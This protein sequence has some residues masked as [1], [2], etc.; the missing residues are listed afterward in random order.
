[1][2]VGEGRE[3]LAGL[4][5]GTYPEAGIGTPAGLGEGVWWMPVAAGSPRPVLVAQAPAPSFLAAHPAAPVLYAVGED[6]QGTVRAWRVRS[7]RERAEA[8]TPRLDLL[9]ESGSGGSQ[10]CHVTVGPG[11]RALYVTNYGS[12]SVA[13]VPLR[14]DGALRSGPTQVFG[15][16]GAGP[17]PGRQDAPHP[18]SGVVAP[19]GRTLLVPDLGTDRVVRYRI[20]ADGG[21]EARGSATVLPPGTGPRHAVFSPDGRWFHLTGELDGQLHTLAWDRSTA[22]ASA[23]PVVPAWA[24]RGTGSEHLSLPSHVAWQ[25]SALVVSVRGPGVLSWFQVDPVT[26]TP[27]AIRQ[28][29]AGGTWPRHFAVLPSRRDGGPGDL[30][31]ADQLSGRVARVSPAATETL[32]TIPSPACIL[33]WAR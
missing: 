17:H 14:P 12:G 6:E 24:G 4:W 1:V 15:H 3:L 9:G 30:V 32:A 23:G 27:S 22:R 18:H 26:G 7:R 16:R 25:G 31:V 21:L 13:V 28:A 5:V 8:V 10:P 11:A 2:S 20:G 19:G 33:R 29:S